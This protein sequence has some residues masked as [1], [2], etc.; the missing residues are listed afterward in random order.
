MEEVRAADASIAPHGHTSLVGATSVCADPSSATPMTCRVYYFGP[1][2]AVFLLAGSRAASGL[3]NAD[4]S[5]Q[6]SCHSRQNGLWAVALAKLE[7]ARFVA[8]QAPSRHGLASDVPRRRRV[9]ESGLASL[10]QAC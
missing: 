7:A 3:P 2:L 5:G 6:E 9:I 4:R 1:N 10:V 8:R